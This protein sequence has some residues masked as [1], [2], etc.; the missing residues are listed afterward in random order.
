[1]PTGFGQHV[2]AL[3]GVPAGDLEM[4]ALHHQMMQL[5]QVGLR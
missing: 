3:I 4:R 1:V 5:S 2:T